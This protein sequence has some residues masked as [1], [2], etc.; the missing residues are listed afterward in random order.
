[1]FVGNSTGNHHM[2]P[3][4]PCINAGD[5]SVIQPDW[6]DI[7]REP[8]V[9][10]SSVDI[11]ANEYLLVTPLVIQTTSLPDG[12]QGSPYSQTLVA[13]GGLP[14]YTWSVASGALPAGLSL[15]AATGV[16]SGTP[17]AKGTSAFTVL[18][19]DADGRTAT[20]ALSIRTR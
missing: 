2:A 1:M 19:T 13:T 7:D 16:I 9:M 18:V 14:P 17:T 4:S 8:R 5:N 15:N 10:G 12:V 3:G 20:K 11:G 6:A